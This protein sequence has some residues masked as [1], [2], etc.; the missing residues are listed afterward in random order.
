MAKKNR[1]QSN[2]IS[3]ITLA[4]KRSPISE[5]YRTIR[6]N[7][8][9][10]AVDGDL[11]SVLVTSSGPG[12]GKST[13]AANL[14]IVFAD[15]DKRVLLIDADMRKPTVA[16]T[17]SISSRLGL[18]NVLS[19]RDLP[20]ADAISITNIPN[21]AIMPSG[22]KP[23]NPS[24]MLS[25]KRMDEVLEELKASFD[26]IIFDMPPVGTVTDAQIIAS[27]VDGTLLVIREG[28]ASKSN[29]IKAKELL[30]MVDANILG[31]VYNGASS[32][33]DGGYYYYY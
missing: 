5:Q 24:E 30:Q 11:S 18:S 1:T 22:P 9:F 15:L 16:T 4:E 13:T 6:T 29:I 17:F 27:K 19:N 33:N 14:A 3:L 10:A 7:I 26:L 31:V 8:Q 25:S 21:V 20:L 23:P 12:E 2:Q 28:N 32:K